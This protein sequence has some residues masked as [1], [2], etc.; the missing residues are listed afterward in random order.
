MS[1][2]TEILDEIQDRADLVW[3]EH[4][5][6]MTCPEEVLDDTRRLVTAL[7]AVLAVHREVQLVFS[8]S[9]GMDAMSPCPDCHGAPGVHPCGCWADQQIEYVCEVCKSP[10]GMGNAGWPCPTVHAITEALGVES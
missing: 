7:R 6:D 8:W 1:D 10:I 5:Y 2:L 4:M 3:D 9:S